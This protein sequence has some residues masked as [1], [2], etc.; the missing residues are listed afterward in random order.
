MFISK[1]KKKTYFGHFYGVRSGLFANVSK[2][3]CADIDVV[4]IGISASKL[5]IP[6]S[7]AAYRGIRFGSTLFAY[8]PT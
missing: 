8:G 1:E 2:L 4:Q 3:D 5:Y 6:W 7:D